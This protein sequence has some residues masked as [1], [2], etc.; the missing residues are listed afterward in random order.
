MRCSIIIFI[1]SLVATWGY[2]QNS[3]S[4]F[5]NDKTGVNPL[6]VSSYIE[7][8]NEYSQQSASPLRQS[9]QV[10]LKGGLH[11]NPAKL[12]VNIKLPYQVSSKTSEGN[13]SGFGNISMAANYVPWFNYNQGILLMTEF[14]LNTADSDFSSDRNDLTLG[15][16]YV[17][18]HVGRSIITPIY[19]QSFTLINNGSST[20]TN[21]G[22]IELR[23]TI[24]S[25]TGNHWLTIYPVF[26][27]DYN[28]GHS[29]FG[30]KI[31]GGTLIDHSV[32]IAIK[33]GITFNSNNKISMALLIR[34]L[35]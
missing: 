28:S 8:G 20:N 35:F 11:L 19:R 27:I 21:Q 24:R 31:E 16:G 12:N 14:N 23:Y 5:I 7:I 10:Y 3:D 1:F 33:P 6:D 29:S 25:I 2:A 4:T 13:L 34:K 26:G 9:D 32:S 22:S 15:A 30:G 17:F 18:Y